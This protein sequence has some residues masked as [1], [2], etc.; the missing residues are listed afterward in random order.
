MSHTRFRMSLRGLAAMV[1]LAPLALA[2]GCNFGTT[3][4]TPFV[5]GEG[6]AAVGK[7]RTR[8]DIG[9]GGGWGA[10]C[11]WMS[12]GGGG[13]VRMRHGLAEK[14]ELGLSAFAMGMES[15]AEKHKYLSGIWLSAK[16]DYKWQVSRYAALV[17]GFGGGLTPYAPFVGGDVGVVVGRPGRR[18]LVPYGAIRLAGSVPVGTVDR[19]VTD[20]DT[21]ETGPIVP[22]VTLLGAAGLQINLASDIA[23][24]FEVGGGGIFP[25]GGDDDGGPGHGGAIYGYMGLNMRFGGK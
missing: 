8:L 9:L 6:P 13:N 3:L 24:V 20:D 5:V 11:G 1:F 16:L 23:L 2:V 25:I 10:C 7:N 4:P 19:I 21:R 14:H 12:G 17:A 22:N 15:K 18:T